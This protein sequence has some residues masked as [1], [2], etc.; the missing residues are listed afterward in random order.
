M[1]LEVYLCIQHHSVFFSL[2]FMEFCNFNTS[3]RLQPLT[4]SVYQLVW[5][6]FICESCTLISLHFCIIGSLLDTSLICIHT[7]SSLISLLGVFCLYADCI[8]VTPADLKSQSF[9]TDQLF[10]FCADI[11]RFPGQG[12]SV[13]KHF[14][15]QH[16]I[17]AC[18]NSESV[19]H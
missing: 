11:K 14:K 4:L 6:L 1:F 7:T 9:S 3:K 10:L 15:L 13:H 16:L 5:I 19:M 2:I 17:C 12:R 8:I 18:T